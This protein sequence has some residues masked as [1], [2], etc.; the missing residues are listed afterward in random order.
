MQLP[1]AV[2][3]LTREL[4]MGEARTARVVAAFP[5]ALYLV[6][7]EGA[8]PR[9]V[10][11]VVTADALLLP[12][13]LRLGLP[14]SSVSWPLALG[15]QAVIGRGSL[16]APGLELRGVRDWRPS[17]IETGLALPGAAALGLLPDGGVLA[18]LCSELAAAAV[19]GQPVESHVAGLVGAG[20]GLT[21]RGDDALCG[22]LLALRAWASSPAPAASVAHAVAHARHRTTDL[23]ASLLM[24]A[25]DGYAVP[26]IVSLLHALAGRG[27]D[28]RSATLVPALEAVL[29][30][31]HSSGRDLVSGLVGTLHV[32]SRPPMPLISS[33]VHVSP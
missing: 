19:A 16:V 26:Q 14:S 27:S 17:R 6:L 2:S 1:A 32:L 15:G 33:P 4:V 10:V 18:R 13:A 7:D 11:P 20:L 25:A 28:P 9:E 23:S 8:G 12:T 24:A 21:P 29:A 5:T 3:P 30:I 22:V 31:G